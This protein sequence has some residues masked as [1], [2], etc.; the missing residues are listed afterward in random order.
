MAPVAGEWGLTLL[1]LKHVLLPCHPATSDSCS[2]LGGA[3]ALLPSRAL[4]GLGQLPLQPPRRAAPTEPWRPGL[5][6][7]RQGHRRKGS[8]SPP[9]CSEEGS[10]GCRHWCVKVSRPRAGDP[11]WRWLGLLENVCPGCR[12][13]QAMSW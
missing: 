3:R 10:G 8:T 12:Q 11:V 4:S 7:G 9:R 2:C 6:P 13:A 5:R 1:P